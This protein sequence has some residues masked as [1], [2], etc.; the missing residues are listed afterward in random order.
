M[1]GWWGYKRGQLIEEQRR[2]TWDI[3]WILPEVHHA[4]ATEP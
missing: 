3:R 2:D 1:G 4:S